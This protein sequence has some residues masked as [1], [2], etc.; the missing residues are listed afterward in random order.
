[1]PTED[2][3]K[4][5]RQLNPT[6]ASPGQKGII[7]RRGMEEAQIG[8]SPLDM[9]PSLAFLGVDFKSPW[10]QDRVSLSL[11]GQLA[12][13][14]LRSFT[15]IKASDLSYINREK[16]VVISISDST[17]KPIFIEIDPSGCYRVMYHNRELLKEKKSQT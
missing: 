14:E 7:T 1:M 16:I 6:P 11:N 4:Q 15:G 12:M 5:V 3:N 13:V 10:L 8:I 17:G 9:E 2:I